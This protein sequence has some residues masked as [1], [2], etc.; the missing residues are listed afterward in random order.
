VNWPPKEQPAGCV[1]LP[2]SR[3]ERSEASGGPCP[4]RRRRTRDGGQQR[5][6]KAPSSVC[7]C[8]ASISTTIGSVCTGAVTATPSMRKRPARSQPSIAETEKSTTLCKV[9]VTLPAESNSCEVSEKLTVTAEMESLSN[10][11]A[12]SV[13]SMFACSLPG[14]SIAPE[15]T[16]RMEFSGS[17]REMGVT[18][19]KASTARV[20]KGW[21]EPS[22]CNL[23]GNVPGRTHR[24]P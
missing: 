4:N 17:A 23:G 16:W 9:A 10:A 18:S 5:R 1:S 7:C 24:C 15:A 22:D 2:R 20:P 21:L 11:V 12:P 8:K 3:A 13:E 14:F 19:G 6:G